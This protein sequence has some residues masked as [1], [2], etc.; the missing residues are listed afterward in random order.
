MFAGTKRVGVL[1]GAA[2]T[3]LMAAACTTAQ[4]AGHAA[5]PAAVYDVQHD[6]IVKDV[7]ADAKSVKVW[8]W[9]PGD[10]DAQ[11]TRSLAI[12]QAPPGAMIVREPTTGSRYLYAEVAEPS[13]EPITL[14]THFVVE[15]DVMSV[16]LDPAKAGQLSDRERVA[17]AEHLRRDVPQMQ[18]NDRIVKLADDVC[19]K[20]TNVVE[21]ARLIYDY[22]VDHS[23]HYSKGAAAP[24]SSGNGSAEYCLDRNGGGCT[25]QHALFIALARA[26]GIPTRLHFGSRLMPKNEGKT[27]DPGYRCWVQYYVPNYGWVAT[28]ASAGDTTEGMRDFYFSGLDQ[29]RIRFAEGRNLLIGEEGQAK[30]VNLIVGAY[31]EVDGKPHSGIERRVTFHRLNPPAAQ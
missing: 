12:Q 29:N 1:M 27:N 10:D 20:Q 11:R 7:P 26:R 21:Q 19:G 30:R 3:S 9:L 31:V 18:V 14:A 22:I 4:D 8:F 28:D 13:G 17:M 25:D 23:D 24:K 15:R 2:M 16:Q 6:L 5:A